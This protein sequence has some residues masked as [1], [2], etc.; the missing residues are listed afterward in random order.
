MKKTLKVAMKSNEILLFKKYIKNS[1]NY[2]EFGSGG[3]TVF[4]YNESNANIITVDNSQE[5]LE[6][7][8]SIIQDPKRL[9]CIYVNTGET[10]EFGQPANYNNKNDWYKYYTSIN[11]YS[12]INID[13]ILVDGRWRVNCALQATKIFPDSIIMIHDFRPRKH[14]HWV[15]EFLEEIEYAETL[16]VFRKK[17]NC[18][19]NKID[20]VIEKLKYQYS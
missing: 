14:Y 19:E 5:W 17:K 20:E 15:L 6:K 3:S 1:K 9:E 10:I 16:S 7:V 4:V 8:S 11:N 18:N 13:T 2:F 12:H